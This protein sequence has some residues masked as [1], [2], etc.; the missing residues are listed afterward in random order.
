MDENEV[1]YTIPNVFGH[2]LLQ[3][4]LLNVSLPVQFHTANPS[5]D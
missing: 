3:G 1:G 2:N 5:K 4:S